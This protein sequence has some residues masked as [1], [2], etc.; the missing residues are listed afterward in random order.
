MPWAVNQN[1]LHLPCGMLIS[2]LRLITERGWPYNGLVSNIRRPPFCYK[3]IDGLITKIE[4]HGLIKSPQLDFSKRQMTLYRIQGHGLIKSPFSTFL[5][6]KSRRPVR[7]KAKKRDCGDNC[8][9]SGPL[10][11]ALSYNE[12]RRPWSYIVAS[13]R[14]FKTP[15]GLIRIQGHGLITEVVR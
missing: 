9:R 5:L 7:F 15:N 1:T 14:F 6:W 10:K 11:K 8:P 2:T 4:G 13:T 12:K 3:A